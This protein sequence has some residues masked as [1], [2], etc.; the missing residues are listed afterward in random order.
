VKTLNRK[1]R[2]QHVTYKATT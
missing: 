1:H 2:N